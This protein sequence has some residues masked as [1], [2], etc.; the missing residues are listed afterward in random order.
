MAVAPSGEVY[1]SVQGGDHA[2]VQ[3]Y[4][5]KG[6]YLRNV[7]NAPTDLHG[8]II[9]PAPDGTPSIFGVSQRAQHVVELSLDGRVEL[10]IPVG[11]IPD[12][13]KNLAPGKPATILSGIAVG[14]NGDIYVVDGYGLD[15]IHRFD[16]TGRYL[17]SFGG[18]GAPWNFDQCHKIVVDPRFKPA[19]LL[20]AD[21]HHSRIVAMD[22]DGKVIGNYAENLRYPSA[23]AIYRNELALAELD[24]R[25][26]I[27]DM[28][29]QIVTSIG[30]ND[31][32]DEIRGNAKAP[33][34]M[35]RPDLFY[36]PHG[37]AY[38]RNG[39]LLVTEWSKWGRVIAI[40]RQLKTASN[41]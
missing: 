26:S 33:P 31:N 16:K 34:D 19:R 14:P 28:K 8:F 12:Q 30:A 29:G 3:V 39:N 24:G 36:S 9:A 15:F 11:V 22:L 38:D 2:G 35:W 6:R 40:D 5:A 37:I 27:L 25:V 13:Y 23:M 17:A 10:D 20:C 32:K 1:V 21:R 41:R 4:S 7:P 18:K